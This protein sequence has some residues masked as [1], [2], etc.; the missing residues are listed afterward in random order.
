[1]LISFVVMRLIKRS[2]D[3]VHFVAKLPPALLGGGLNVG[4]A[5][6]FGYSVMDF[7]SKSPNLSPQMNGF[8]MAASFTLALVA[9]K[10]ERRSSNEK[11]VK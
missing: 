11:S 9:L 8:L 7:F 6:C 10:Y 2:V 4:A 1:M 5:G 3:V